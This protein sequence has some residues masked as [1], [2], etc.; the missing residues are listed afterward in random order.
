L[1]KLTVGAKNANF[2][3]FVGENIFKI[4]ISVPGIAVSHLSNLRQAY[5]AASIAGCNTLSVSRHVF[6]LFHL[7]T[8][9]PWQDVDDSGRVILETP[10]GLKPDPTPIGERIKRMKEDLVNPFSDPRKS[11]F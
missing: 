3:P 5:N 11:V 2:L 8:D 6:E 10:L 1:Q 7:S 9:N 4:I